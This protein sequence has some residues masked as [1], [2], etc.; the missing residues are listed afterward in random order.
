MKRVLITIAILCV[1]SYAY[2]TILN[3]NAQ[4]EI[5]K[6]L[7]RIRNGVVSCKQSMD[8][9]ITKLDSLKTNYSS[10]VDATDG[11]NLNGILSNIT[12]ISADLGLAKTDIDND[13][14]T[15]KE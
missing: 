12:D 15:I 14:P 5:A 13:F 7:K 1:A 8:S 9:S 10:E 6:E 4:A 11:V 2:A 3:T